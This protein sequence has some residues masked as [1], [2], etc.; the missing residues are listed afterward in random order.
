[1]YYEYMKSRVWSGW[2]TPTTTVLFPLHCR[3]GLGVQFSFLPT[4]PCSW[5]PVYFG[6]CEPLCGRVC[7]RV[8]VLW[9]FS[10]YRNTDPLLWNTVG[11]ETHFFTSFHL[12]ALNQRRPKP[13]RRMSRGSFWKLWG[14]SLHADMQNICCA[15]LSRFFSEL[16]FSTYPS[17]RCVD[18]LNLCRGCLSIEAV[19]YLCFAWAKV[20]FITDV[21]VSMC[22]LTLN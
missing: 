11:I 14:V 21:H 2:T 6:R 19:V 4:L 20:F 1:M 3:S 10:P 5:F 15:F 18:V 7:V 8:C 16:F 13:S 9:I 12:N 17:S 22:W